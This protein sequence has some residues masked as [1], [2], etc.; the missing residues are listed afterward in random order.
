MA[1]AGRLSAMLLME[2]HMGACTPVFL[3]VEDPLTVQPTTLA[4]PMPS[5][6]TRRRHVSGDV[7]H[8]SGQK[9]VLLANDRRGGFS[10][11]IQE[12]ETSL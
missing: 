11:E 2:Y 6:D 4:V 3:L 8:R 12:S 10:V 9:L 1:A 7:P 5:A